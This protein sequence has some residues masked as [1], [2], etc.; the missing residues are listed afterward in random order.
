MVKK[1]FILLS[2]VGI[3]FSSFS[4]KPAVQEN[5]VGLRTESFGGLNLHSS[6]LGI[7]FSQVK[8]KTYKIRYLYSFDLVSMKH[9]KESKIT[10]VASNRESSPFKFAKLNSFYTAR[11]S[12]GRKYLLY[13]KYR[14]NGVEIF[15]NWKTGLDI[16]ILKPVY[17][18]IIRYDTNG[19]AIEPFSEEKYDP[20]IHNE[21]NIWGKGSFSKGFNDLSFV[22]GGHI[23]GGF[24]FEFAKNREKILAIETGV[25]IDY[26]PTKVP[27]MAFN[28]ENDIFF[29]LYINLL[30]GRKY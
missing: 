24:I 26:Y 8:F 7:T 16:G 15:W 19:F 5:K 29:N 13:E 9:P 27:I 17:L 14:E 3:G 21:S 12:Y 10:Y 2:F 23:K 20:N 30:F 18:E 25:I 1:I 4:Q 11:F 22:L 28:K 6:G